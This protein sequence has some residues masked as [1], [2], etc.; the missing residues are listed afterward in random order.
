MGGDPCRRSHVGVPSRSKVWVQV[1][2]WGSGSD[3]PTSGSSETEDGVAWTDGDG[4]V[5]ETGSVE[6]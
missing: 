1:T 5:D 2:S 4:G 6:V 3:F